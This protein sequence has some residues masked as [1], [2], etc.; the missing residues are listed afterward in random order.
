MLRRRLGATEM[1]ADTAV[2]Q[3]RQLPQRAVLVASGLGERWRERRQWRFQP[4]IPKVAVLWHPASGSLQLENVRSAAATLNLTLEVLEVSRPADF[5]LV[6]QAMA[7]SQA[8]AVLMLSSALFGRTLPLLAD[9]ALR[10]RL[11]AI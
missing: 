2:Y 5:D 7:K 11:P 1:M 3:G 4:A 10:N 6:F 9:L 8:A